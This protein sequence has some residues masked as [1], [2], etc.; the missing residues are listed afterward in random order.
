MYIETVVIRIVCVL[1]ERVYGV[2][3][4]EADETADDHSA[5]EK[6]DPLIGLFSV[7][8]REIGQHTKYQLKARET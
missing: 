4:I 2:A 8:R 7:G 5:T 6:V 3:D 1:W